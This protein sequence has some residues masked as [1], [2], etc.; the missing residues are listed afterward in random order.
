MKVIFILLSG[1]VFFL[2]TTGFLKGMETMLQ[3]LTLP[4]QRFTKNLFP[5][6]FINT[7]IAKLK[8]ENAVLFKKIVDQKELEKENRALRD[9]FQTTSISSRN[10]IPA[11]IIGSLDY[12][13]ID[14][15]ERD[16]L[17]IGQAV[18]FKDQLI[19]KITKVSSRFSVV[20]VITNR[21]SSFTVRTLKTSALGILKGQGGE[22]GMILDNVLLSE[23]LEINDLVL[24]KGNIDSKGIG[25][26]PNLIVG[27]IVSVEKKPSALFQKAV[28]ESIMDFSKLSTVFVIKGF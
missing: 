1:F 28:V 27:K 4:I 23:N 6:V 5:N 2:A 15:G 11:K 26:P 18:V 16:N 17:K 9:Q 12:F 8:E 25:F 13:V 3:N 21:S 24:T 14:K 7:E 22:S 20:T 19:G 10:L